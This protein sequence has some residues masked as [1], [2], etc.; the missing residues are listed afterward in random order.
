MTQPDG[1]VF[2]WKTNQKNGLYCQWFL[3]DMV[4]DGV[5]YNCCEQYM[6]AQKAELMG[7]HASK[8]RIMEEPSPWKQKALGR[9]VKHWDEKLWNAKCLAIVIE[10]NYAK[11]SQHADLRRVLMNTR[12]CVLAEASPLDCKWGIGLSATHPHAADRTKW[13]GENL[14]GEALMAV[15]KRLAE[16]SQ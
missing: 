3:C 13:R 15:R 10:A 11:F 4:V 7:D 8:R 1:P 12:D 5:A 9:K 6:M 16:E 14:L 2:F